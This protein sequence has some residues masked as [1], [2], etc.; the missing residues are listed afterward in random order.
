M[1]PPNN[2]KLVSTFVQSTI[3]GLL[4]AIVVDHTMKKGDLLQPNC[5]ARDEFHSL[6]QFYSY[7]LCEHSLPITKLFHFMATFNATIFLMMILGAK[8]TSTKLRIF[9]FTLFQAYGLA[10]ISHFWLEKN[11]PATFKYPIYSF[12]C[13]WIM[14]KDALFGRVSL[15]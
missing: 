13:D 6:D 12:A 11:K 5:Q 10:W 15:F 14:F 8:S 4:L 1:G 7:Y 2:K 3:C 9:V